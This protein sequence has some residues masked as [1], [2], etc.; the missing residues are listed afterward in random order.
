MRSRLIKGWRQVPRPKP[1]PGS[2]Y[3]PLPRGK[4][5]PKPPP[6]TEAAAKDRWE[7]EGGSA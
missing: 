4:A 1:G 7:S 6:A 5:P 3:L 2:R